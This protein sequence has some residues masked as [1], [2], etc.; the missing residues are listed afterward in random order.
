MPPMSGQSCLD[1]AGGASV[2]TSVVA[3]TRDLRVT[4]NPALAATAARTDRRSRARRY[5]AP[6]VDHQAAVA[7][8]RA[9]QR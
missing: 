5:P 2:S 8:W 1:E 7:P 3:F 4:D 6:I 9:R